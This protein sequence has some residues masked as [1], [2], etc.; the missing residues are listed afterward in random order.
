MWSLGDRAEVDEVVEITWLKREKVKVG[1]GG[2]CR[3][4]VEMSRLLLVE[5]LDKDVDLD[6]DL[7]SIR[8]RIQLHRN[9][10]VD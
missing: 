7:G 3:M 8:K 4:K 2:G 9:K 10:V 5:M 1:G 6:V